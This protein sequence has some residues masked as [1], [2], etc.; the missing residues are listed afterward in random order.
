MRLRSHAHLLESPLKHI[1]THPLLSLQWNRHPY[2]TTSESPRKEIAVLGGGITG[3]ACAYYIS[4][5]RPRDNI[6]IYEAG[7]RLGGWMHSTHV[8]VPG[9]RVLFEHGPRTLRPGL[10]GLVTA[11]LIQELGLIPDVIFTPKTAASA[12]NRYVYY[13][14]HLVRMP[15]YESKIEL[16]RRLLEEPAFRGLIW[17]VF[18]EIF[19]PK[20]PADLTDES[21]GSFI[22][23][24]VDPRVVNNLV[25]A[26]MHGIYAG[27]VWQLSAKSLAPMHWYLE[28][29]FGSTTRGLFDV[30]TT[31]KASG[32]NPGAPILRRDADMIK[33]MVREQLEPDFRK[34]LRECSVYSFRNGIQELVEH[35]AESMR[36]NARISIKLNTTVMGLKL[37]S[38]DQG[39]IKV[40]EDSPSTK[41]VVVSTL[42]SKTLGN[43]CI[44]DDGK[45]QLPALCKTHAVTVMVVNLYF[46]NPKLLP[47]EGF[48]YLIPQSV[49]FAQNPERAL[50]VIFDSDAM[51]G[52]DTV[53][54]TKITVMLGGHW[55]DGWGEYPSEEEGINMARSILA[56]HLRITE[57]P[58]VAR[59][60]LH[61]D[62]IPQYTVGHDERMRIA[63]AQLKS[64][65]GGRLQVVGSSY[66]GVGVNDC[67]RAARDIAKGLG[68]NVWLLGEARTGLDHFLDNHSWVLPGGK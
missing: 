30:N 27:D 3:L 22:S 45:T 37:E 28:G 19:R 56:R 43:L 32:D 34:A 2:S 20:R 63:H 55:W 8:E 42:F 46:T 54:G 4:K 26:L 65:F 58:A 60:N 13:P 11:H 29:K 66:T 39:G 21:L 10:N 24:R 35:L 1:S 25:S 5:E 23:R 48:G 53:D 47:V 68:E 61:R 57:S 38:K 49:P 36:S 50:G 59:A 62:C 64:A 14:D 16:A 7:P 51:K 33:E 31:N 40:R 17:G 9:G 52:Q 41:D 12:R 15:P 18:G 6:T 44:S 67:I